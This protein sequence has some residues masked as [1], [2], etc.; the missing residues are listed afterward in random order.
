MGNRQ[1]EEMAHEDA[2]RTVMSQ[3]DRKEGG[4]QGPMCITGTLETKGRNENHLYT[5][6]VESS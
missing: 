6:G 1:E 4:G 2:P 5:R 3:G